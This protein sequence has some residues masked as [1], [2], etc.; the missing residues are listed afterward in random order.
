MSAHPG[1][2]AAYAAGEQPS[3]VVLDHLV[4][5]SACRDR[6]EFWRSVGTAVTHES[7]PQHAVRAMLLAAAASPEPVSSRRGL[8]RHAAFAWQLLLAQ[9]RLVRLSVWTAS[10]LVMGLA[11][12]AVVVGDVTARSLLA[13][14]APFVAAAGIAG[15][16][17]PGLEL[18]ASTPTS[19]RVVL[20]ARVTLVFAYDLVLA[21]V[22][23][24]VL[25]GAGADASGAGA[26]VTAWLGPMVLLSSVCLLVAVAVGTSTAITVGLALWVTR[27]L[28]PVLATDTHWLAPVASAITLF[29]ATNLPT[30]LLAVALLCAAVP[31]AGRISRRTSPV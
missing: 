30:C 13:M 3:A 27:L 11:V 17:D 2:L 16:R 28:A 10:A 26:L 25:A 6:L 9:F 4:V 14:V 29:W 20:V 24:W 31:L 21:L 15:V 1:D 8:P 12:L 7:P 5:C 23:S 19:P 18:L 22:S